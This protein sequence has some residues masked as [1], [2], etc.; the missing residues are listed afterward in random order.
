MSKI[1]QYLDLLFRPEDY[2]VA[3]DLFTTRPK[4]LFHVNSVVDEFITINPIHPK[5]D[6]DTKHKNYIKGLGRR[7]D[8]NV[9]Q[10]RN[11]FLEFD[12][13]TI[14]EQINLVTR[15]LPEE[16]IS[17]VTFSGS[18]S[19]HA[20]IALDSPISREDHAL[21]Y[22]TLI[23]KFPTTD[24][25]MRNPSRYTRLPGHIRA[26]TGREQ[27]LLHL[28]KGRV[29]T[30]KF[31]AWINEQERPIGRAPSPKPVR[32]GSTVT[33]KSNGVRGELSA[34]TKD[35][36][37]R[38][39]DEGD[40]YYRL[41]SAVSDM[42]AQGYEYEEALDAAEQVF[43]NILGR[44]LERKFLINIQG[45]YNYSEGAMK[46]QYRAPRKLTVPGYD[47]TE[48]QKLLVELE[49]YIGVKNETKS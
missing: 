28:A 16:F 20:V 9:S 27:S 44:D 1:K 31:M 21:V 43:N 24:T 35:W 39:S 12:S 14:E 38:G 6:M 45:I 30:A 48:A 36:L 15:S 46:V 10:I 37:R 40:H 17:A 18:K 23:H 47:Y 41:V 19:I 42:R 34:K 4:P 13:G 2:V 5:M 3:G 32:T 29:D 8:C 25:T 49:N 33:L 7:A 11:V 22:D 26:S